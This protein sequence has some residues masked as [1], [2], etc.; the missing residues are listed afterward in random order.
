MDDVIGEL[1]SLLIA[2]E[3]LELE[4]E[5]IHAEVENTGTVLF[6]TD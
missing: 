4:I 2:T 1:G 6:V 5:R 3:Q